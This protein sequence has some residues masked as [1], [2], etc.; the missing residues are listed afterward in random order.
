MV[1]RASR[2]G[3]LTLMIRYLFAM[4]AAVMLAALGS[5]AERL[6]R[7]DGPQADAQY[8]AKNRDARLER[9]IAPAYPV[10]VQ[11]ERRA[12][13][14]R[15]CFTVDEQGALR[16]AEVLSGDERFHEAALAALGQWRFQPAMENGKLV[17]RSLQTTFVFRVGRP[18]TM[19]PG[20]EPPYRF[21]DSPVTP[22]QEGHSPD[23]VYPRHLVKRELAG[24]VELTLG[25]DEQGS[26]TGV[27]VSRATHP[28]FVAAALAAVEQWKLTPARRGRLPVKGEKIAVL[29]F[30]V[31]DSETQHASHEE[32]LEQNGIRLA[33]PGAPA[34]RLYFDRIPEAVSFVDPVYPAEL[35]EKGVA[36][37][38]VV[39]FSVDRSGAVVAAT[40]SRASEEAFGAALLAAVSAWRFK[41]L[42]HDGEAAWVDFQ[43]EW[44]FNLPKERDTA[45]DLLA[46]LAPDAPRAGARQLDGK[47]EPLYLC[48]PVLPPG[49]TAGGEAEI[50]I[51]IS[52]SGRACWPRITKA[53]TPAVGW[54]AATAVS[55]W[56]FAT[57]RQAGRPVHVRV[58]VP[59]EVPAGRR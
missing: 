57:P 14:V 56:Y 2:A 45:P 53:D 43:V 16:D 6:R 49:E 52:P 51:T 39:D 22:P 27:E 48:A 1:G 5:A 12:I 42:Y 24:E 36:G 4:G 26:V 35:R 40:V 34:P 15:V 21:E 59:V 58:I 9:W 30:K 33:E 18:T 20:G 13:R 25:V 10:A 50:E 37:E 31:M 32:W 8:F 7:D 38:A 46:A 41:P 3:R 29:R 23:P 11:E 55:R 28:D 47:I 54:A 44:K 19:E 17:A